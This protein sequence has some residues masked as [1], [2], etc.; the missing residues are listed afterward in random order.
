MRL[1]SRNQDAKKWERYGG[2]LGA[3]IDELNGKTVGIVGFGNIGKKVAEKA[4]V[5]GM[6]VIAT[7]SENFKQR[8]EL[9]DVWVDKENLASLL[10]ESDFVV[11][12]LPLIAETEGLI[13]ESQL[14]GMKNTGYLLNVSRGK[15]VDEE[16]L[17]RALEEKWISGAG[18]DVFVEEPLPLKS[19]LWQM[20][21]VVITPHVAGITKHFA[22]DVTDVFCENLRRYLNNERL[23]FVVD[24]RK[25][26]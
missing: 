11:L 13:G 23:N 26:Y 24:K 2:Y 15:I 18:L 1:F 12:T 9:V 7:R 20:D 14:K 22:E 8:E 4:K 25:G 3:G 5:F 10:S 21:N 19:K 6:K 16:V 17:V